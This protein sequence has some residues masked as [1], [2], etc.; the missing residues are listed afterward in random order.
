M[1]KG[2]DPKNI[3]GTLQ[4]SGLCR[5]TNPTY[6]IVFDLKNIEGSKWD[7]MDGIHEFAHGYNEVLE[8]HILNLE[9]IIQW[10][11]D[12]KIEHFNMFFGWAIFYEDEL[13]RF[14]LYDRFE[15]LDKNYLYLVDYKERIDPV[16]HT[17]VG[18]K[19][20]LQK[21]FKSKESFLIA[22]GKYGGMTEFV[23]SLSDETQN[24]YI[25]FYDTHLNT[26]ANYVWYSKYYRKLFENWGI[27]DFENQIEEDKILWDILKKIFK[28]NNFAFIESYTNGLKERNTDNLYKTQLR[29]KYYQKFFI[30]II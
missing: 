20:V 27:I 8:A 26:Y 16:E 25:S 18:I 28:V 6:D 21:F 9:N 14:N 10:N 19:K 5:Q 29:D 15:K 23:A 22:G 7:Y 12:K 24:Y 11:K 30:N 3:Y 1:D 2:I 17:C 13:K 4:L